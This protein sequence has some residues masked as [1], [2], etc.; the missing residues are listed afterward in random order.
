MLFVLT[1]R[2]LG[3]IFSHVQAK[4]DVWVI[5]AAM[6]GYLAVPRNSYFF[7]SDSKG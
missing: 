7:T 2:L 4:N 1:V 6:Y 3:W 5:L